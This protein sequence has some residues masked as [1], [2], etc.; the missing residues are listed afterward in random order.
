M[1]VK[2]TEGYDCIDD[3][4]KIVLKN[5]KL[6]IRKIFK[7]LW[8][9]K[10]DEN[11]ETLGKGLMQINDNKYSQL[12]ENYNIKYDIYEN[13]CRNK[14]IELKNFGTSTIIE[15]KEI[16]KIINDKCNSKHI[17]ILEVDTFNYIY[18]K[19]YKKY[20]GTHS[21]ILTEKIGNLAKIVDVWYELYNVEVQYTEL[22]N[23]ITR[24]I[25]L[26]ISDIQEKDIDQK[27]LKE[28]VI[29]E[30]SIEE[31]KKFFNN[32]KEVDLKKEYMDLN[33]EMVFKAPLDKGL[34]KIVMNRQRFAYYLYY[35][36]EKF[37]DKKIKE[38]GECIFI[39][40][41]DWMRL[42]SILV[43]TY[44]LEKELEFEKINKITESIL[45][46]EIKIK[47]EIEDLIW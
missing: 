25:I 24:I 8:Y 7:N 10:F 16:D 4:L 27:E 47:K 9:F 5:K 20:I 19:G 17:I 26:D 14:Q 39:I 31:M 21:C 33:I 46:K 28:C 40:S 35:L 36:S 37:N 11:R 12:K 29:D 32:L 34:R 22:L 1:E 2:H 3:N 45:E 38:L 42:R 15:T 18:D 23:S 13:G 6:D 41:M 44:F 30:I 43:Q